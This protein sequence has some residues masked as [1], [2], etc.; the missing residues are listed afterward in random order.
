M[1]PIPTDTICALAT[2]PGRGGIGVIRISGPRT[3]DIVDTVTGRS[4]R[5]RPGHT[6]HRAVISSDGVVIDDVLLALFHAPKSYT[7]E[8]VVE[9]HAHGGPLPLR[10]ILQRLYS[11]GARQAGPGEFTLRAYLNGKMDLAQA[12]AVADVIAADTNEAFSLARSQMA[13][14]LS[15]RVGEIRDKVLGVLARIEASIDFPEDVGELDT[16]ACR[17]DI[18]QAAWRVE[19]LLKSADAGIIY[20]EGVKLVL[21]GRPNVGKSSLMNAL[22]KADRSIVTPIPG[23]TRDM[24]EESANICG[25]KVKIVDTAGVRETN[26]AV[27]IIG[28]ERT[29]SS[30]ATADIAVL[31]VD[32]TVGLTAEEIAIQSDLG[33]TP[34]I[35]AWNKA[36]IA[37]TSAPAGVVPVSALTG[38]NLDRLEMAIQAVLLRGTPA[39]D[40]MNVIVTH[41]RHRHALKEALTQ[42]NH[43]V[44]TIDEYLPADFIS[45][46]VRGALTALGE[47]TGA[48]A[49]EDIINEIFSRFCIGK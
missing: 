43:A 45:I 11:L 32:G 33:E 34:T 12:E 19:D 38:L 39:L 26:D 24:I 37:S 29:M 44:E 15:E 20:R 13:G 31:V 4:W 18:Q 21:V 27:E 28:V 17:E 46:D 1:N 41:S 23:T 5:R 22:L 42:L 49:T 48:T 14:V 30:L 10:K 6:L 8:D 47:I 35:V 7:G 16:D 36:D 9:I 3:Y 2:P 25:I 40:D